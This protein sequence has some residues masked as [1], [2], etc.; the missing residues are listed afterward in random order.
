MLH[1][2]VDKNVLLSLK[3]TNRLWPMTGSF[4]N[5]YFISSLV[6]AAVGFFPNY[7]RTIIPDK[8]ECLSK[9]K[10]SNLV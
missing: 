5:S 9:T 3:W 8:S 2:V 1:V 6:R 10:Q 7:L 4:A